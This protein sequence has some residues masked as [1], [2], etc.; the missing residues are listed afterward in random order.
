V[1]VALIL[2]LVISY[3]IYLVPWLHGGGS[4]PGANFSA[5]PGSVSSQGASG[6]PV[7]HAPSPPQEVVS[8]NDGTILLLVPGGT[9]TVG[10]TNAEIKQALDELRRGVDPSSRQRAQALYGSALETGPAHGVTL[11]PYYIGKYEVTN[12]Q[13]RRFV[14]ASG[15]SP[16]DKEWQEY[17]DKWGDDAPVV[18]VSWD[19]AT[20]YCAWA[21]LRLP[22]E[23]EWEAAARGSDGRTY[24]WGN[25]WDASRCR[26]DVG[27]GGR[28]RWEQ[29]GIGPGVERRESFQETLDAVIKAPE[30]P[31][32][33]AA[34]VGSYPTDCSPFGALDMAGNVSEWTSSVYVRYPATP[35]SMMPTNGQ[36]KRVVRGGS[37]F[38]DFPPSFRAAHRQG[39]DPDEASLVSVHPLC[40]R[41]QWVTTHK[42][43][44]NSIGICPTGTT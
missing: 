43:R 22:T 30:D 37:W 35:A 7:A 12:A 36:K 31:L 42:R 23:D 34:A 4:H 16:A 21:G 20:A 41:M 32:L 24:P 13:F 2:C 28:P 11:A 25:Q 9:Y 15:Y 40:V 14:A 18:D 8:A 1:V 17:A 29:R 26:N 33:R 44:Q 19:D 3:V 27:R 6:A 5:A 10:S 39:R 38:D